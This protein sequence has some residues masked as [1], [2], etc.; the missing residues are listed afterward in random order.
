M[1]Q[2]IFHC[3]NCGAKLAAGL[4]EVGAEFECPT[5]QRTQIVPG[6]QT[7]SA[8]QSAQ[9]APGT[10]SMPAAHPGGAP[11]VQIP[12]KKIIIPAEPREEE[13]V[14]EIYVE[15]LGGGG[16]A[17]F[18]VALGTAG[19]LLCTISMVWM[20]LSQ[21]EGQAINWSMALMVFLATFLMGLMGLVLAQLARLVVR[22]ADRVAR[23][24]SEE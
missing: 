18:A 20:Y 8:A 21:R 15:P 19:L 5:C 14:E 13:E 22:L 4:D 17:L 12:R 9:T 1:G 16:L 11:V 10:S 24:T 6:A 23:L 7:P 2:I 3:S